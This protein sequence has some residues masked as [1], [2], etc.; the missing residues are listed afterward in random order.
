MKLERFRKMQNSPDHML[1][2]KNKTVFYKHLCP[3]VGCEKQLCNKGVE[4]GP[5]YAPPFVLGKLKRTFNKTIWIL[6]AP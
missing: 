1:W 5:Q 6:T 3:D 4:C 2:E